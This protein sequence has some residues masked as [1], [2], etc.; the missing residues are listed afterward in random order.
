MPSRFLRYFIS[1][2]LEGKV[3]TDEKIRDFRRV[4]LAQAGLI[5]SVFLLSLLTYLDMPYHMEIS[6]TL[7]FA[8]LGLYCFC[9][10]DMLRNY[11]SNRRIIRMNLFIIMGVFV[12]G[13]VGVNP[14]IPMAPT[15]SY[16]IFL[17][18]V[19]LCLL[20]VE[21]SVIYYTIREFFKKDLGLPIKLWGAAAIYLMIGF[22]FASIYEILCII[23]LDCL[24][25]DVPLRTVA[26]MKRVAYS[27]TI[28]SGMDSPWTG[29]SEL[30]HAM[31]T[32][33]ALW[34]QI[35]I[36]LIVGRLLVNNV[37]GGKSL[38]S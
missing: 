11:T 32:I 8:I 28:L 2:N 25:I 6:E 38:S 29:A 3:L 7:F 14:F 19:Q 30:L 4:V 17:A 21:S 24:G 34:G 23:Q 13:F 16:R 36:V 15:L 37:T 9:L 26:F 5:F 31:G 35:F 22:A 12:M 18:F 10:W 1:K 20:T 33:E 27:M